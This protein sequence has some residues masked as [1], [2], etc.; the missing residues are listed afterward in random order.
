MG[1][2]MIDYFS[3]TK[4]YGYGM[5]SSGVLLTTRDL[6]VATPSMGMK[7]SSRRF[8]SGGVRLILERQE[9]G[10]SSRGEWSVVSGCRGRVVFYAMVLAEA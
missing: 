9:V 5:Q 4:F 7:G 6:R 2:G 8:G 10:I 1:E 3:L